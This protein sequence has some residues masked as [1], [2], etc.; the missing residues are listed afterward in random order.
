MTAVEPGSAAPTGL[1]EC[2]NE[3]ATVR[4]EFTVL[5]AAG[6]KVEQELRKR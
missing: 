5:R 6:S 2:E 4:G 3:L 1:L